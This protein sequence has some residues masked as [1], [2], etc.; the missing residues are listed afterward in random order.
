MDSWSIGVSTEHYRCQKV[1][2]KD[3]R[4]ERVTDT[5]VYKHR[6]I[7]NPGVSAADAIALL[8]KMSAK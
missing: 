1:Y 4:A 7:T 6:K 8:P 2:M 3:T 5:L